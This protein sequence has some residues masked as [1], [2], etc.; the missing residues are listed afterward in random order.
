MTV[1]PTEVRVNNDLL[2]GHPDLRLVQRTGPGPVDLA[3]PAAHYH[4]VRAGV[5]AETRL[6]T[7]EERISLLTGGNSELPSR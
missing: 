7:S 6:R 1:L 4:V 3:G 5:P 2:D